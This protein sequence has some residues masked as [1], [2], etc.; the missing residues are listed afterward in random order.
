MPTDYPRHASVTLLLGWA[1]F[2]AAQQGGGCVIIQIQSQSEIAEQRECRF[3]RRRQRPTP[4]AKQS[5]AKKDEVAPQMHLARRCDSCCCHDAS[6]I[7][8]SESR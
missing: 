6:V 5:S 1:A 4:K 3:Q 2:G 8:L 7:L